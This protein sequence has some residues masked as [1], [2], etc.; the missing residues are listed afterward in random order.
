MMAPCSQKV[1]HEATGLVTEAAPFYPNQQSQQVDYNDQ[2][3]DYEHE[4]P[5]AV[6]Y[7]DP[8]DEQHHHH[9]HHQHQ[10]YQYAPYDYQQQQSQP[11]SVELP[12]KKS[13]ADLGLDSLGFVSD[14]DDDSTQ[15]TTS[16]RTHHTQQHATNQLEGGEEGDGPSPAYTSGAYRRSHMHD[17]AYGHGAE[18]QQDNRFVGRGGGDSVHYSQAH[19]PLHHASTGHDPTMLTQQQQYEQHF[20]H[21]H[22]PGGIDAQQHNQHQ[23][24][25]GGGYPGGWSQYPQHHQHQYH[26]QYPPEHHQHHHEHQEQGGGQGVVDEYGYATWEGVS[27]NGGIGPEE[28]GDL[29]EHQFLTFLQESFPGYS[30][31]SLED[32]LAAN[33]HDI[34]LT[35][36]MLTDLDIEEKPPEPPPLD[37]ESNFPTLG[38]GDGAGGN[39]N[40]KG[41]VVDTRPP[42]PPTEIFRSFTISGGRSN[43]RGGASAVTSS[44]VGADENGNFADRVRTQTSIPTPLAATTERGSVQIGY[45]SGHFGGGGGGGGRVSRASAAASHQPWVE[46]GDAVSNLYASTR[47]DARDHMR[48][49]NICFQQ[50]TQAYLT[51]NKALAKELSR[52]GRNHAR[53]M[54]AAHEEAAGTIFR[55]RNAN[56]QPQGTNNAGVDGGPRMFDL[57]GLHVAEAVAVLRR[58]LPNCR[59]VGERVVHVLVGTGHHVKGSRTPARLPAAVAEFLHASRIRYWEPQAGMLEVDVASIVVS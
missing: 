27:R 32:L 18:Q 1:A 40:N 59:A 47:E 9:H 56:I 26:Q 45:G 33:N 13:L 41:A 57:H 58:E 50:A 37:D 19:V 52:K 10:Y 14:E 24:A 21:H 43:V 30:L 29:D 25:N 46:T 39:N 17:G 11:Q 6:Y 38:G 23:Y 49:R 3:Q 53:A 8:Y 20:Q 28:M 2:Q 12:K 48:L 42:S 51:G 15:D 22:Q 35:V 54:K 55:E 34:S 4:H 44:V 7:V 31:E 5:Q 16:P 36:E